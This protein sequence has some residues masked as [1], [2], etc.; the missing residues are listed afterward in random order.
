MEASTRLEEQVALLRLAD[1][2][3]RDF[4]AQARQD[5]ARVK[6][7]ESQVNMAEDEAQQVCLSAS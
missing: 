1:Q 5:E 7:L 4:V 2:R 6:E 3:E